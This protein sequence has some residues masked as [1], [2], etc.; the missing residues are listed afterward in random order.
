VHHEP[1]RPY[2]DSGG[3]EPVRTIDV[4]L[5]D[6]M[7]AVP[8]PDDQCKLPV[9]RLAGFTDAVLAIAI[10][11]LIL[12]LRLP[13]H[14]DQHLFRAILHEWPSYLAYAA[15]FVTIGV[16]WLQH[17]RV[18]RSLRMADANL[19]RL[20]LLVLLFASFLP[21]PTKIVVEEF[22]GDWHPHPSAVVFYG[23]TLLALDLA[24][25]AFLRYGAA[26]R[27]LATDAIAEKRAEAALRHQPSYAYYAAATVIG[28]FVP[29]AGIALCFTISLIALLTSRPLH[30]VVRRTA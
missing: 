29:I 6:I 15:S 9:E 1:E 28:Y 16:V 30:H 23:L 11:I 12:E 21:F 10:T 20:N 7:L 13:A 27:R 19:Y 25:L 5:R 14:G 22:V 26:H 24:M 17:A 18:A 4:G 8:E 3:V 2:R